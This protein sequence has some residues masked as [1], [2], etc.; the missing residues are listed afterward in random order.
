MY[1]CVNGAV[2]PRAQLLPLLTLMVF[3]AEFYV[4]R[5]F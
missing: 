3:L 2:S 5:C 1:A 4:Y